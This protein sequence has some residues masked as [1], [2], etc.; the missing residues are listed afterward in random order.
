MLDILTII[1]GKKRHHPT[2]WWSFNAICCHHRG[3]KVDKRGRGG[4]IYSDQDTW[5]YSCFNCGFKCGA[6][7]GKHFSGNTKSFLSW[8][9]VDSDE[10]D[11]LSFQCFAKKTIYDIVPEVK[12][13]AIN[14]ESRLLPEKSVR[15]D[16][17]KSE[18]EQYVKYLFDR[19]LSPDS[20][21][22]YVTPDTDI[23]RDRERLIIPYYWKSKIVGYTSRYYDG[24][25]PKYVSEQQRGYVFN[26]DAQRREW[27]V[28]LLVEGQFDAISIDGCAYLG[29][30]ILDEQARLLSGLGKKIIVVPDRDKTG[31]TVCD[32]ALELGYSISIPEWADD[33][34][35]AN[36]AVRKY[37]KLGTIMSIL[38]AA[39]HSKITVEMNRRK[40]K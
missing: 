36:D 9:G 31:M 27:S 33:V 35:D 26:V 10:I 17:K 1:P 30:T 28:C 20:Y 23:L 32:R 16:S 5:S 39:T 11:K 19:G 14:F 34:K 7:P 37:G 15:L 12:S 4:V 24:R 13:V 6:R 40:F 21:Q 3:H 22:Y 38:Q 2:G 8:C 18:H 25:K 29:S